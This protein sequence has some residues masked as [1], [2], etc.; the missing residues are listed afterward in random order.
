M[1]QGKEESLSGKIVTPGI[2]KSIIKEF[3]IKETSKGQVLEIL[4]NSEEV[5]DKDI[6]ITLGFAN[7][8][9]DKK[10]NTGFDDCYS[11]LKL[12]AVKCNAGIKEQQNEFQNKL[13]SE[14]GCPT[15]VSEIDEYNKFKKYILNKPL[16]LKWSG[17]KKDKYWN[18]QLS[19]F[20]FAATIEEGRD[21]I[22]FDVDYDAKDLS[23]SIK[24]NDGLEAVSPQLNDNPF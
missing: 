17:K 15:E 3:N 2:Y 6:K 10:D 1:K 14:I 24:P 5:S 4:V 8:E 21:H 13:L 16:F 23:K 22:Q 20:N 19:K 9:K 11:K 18:F 12:L 7:D